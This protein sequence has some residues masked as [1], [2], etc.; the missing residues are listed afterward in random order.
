MQTIFNVLPTR[1]RQKS[2]GIRNEITSL[3]HYV[4]D[5]ADADITRIRVLQFLKGVRS[6]V[7]SLV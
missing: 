7:R 2:A 6:L 5:Y 4:L 3:S 1:W